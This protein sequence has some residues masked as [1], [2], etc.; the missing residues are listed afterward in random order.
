MHTDEIAL[1]QADS[2]S[3]TDARCR[4]CGYMNMN[5]GQGNLLNDP[6]IDMY[7]LPTSHT[8][9]EATRNSMAQYTHKRKF[10]LPE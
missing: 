1:I 10:T 8:M 3:I 2:A 4:F 9:M 7:E 5:D 6:E